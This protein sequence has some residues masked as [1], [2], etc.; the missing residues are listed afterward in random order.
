MTI[1]NLFKKKNNSVYSDKEVLYYSK[2]TY[3]VRDDYKPKQYYLNKLENINKQI[4]MYKEKYNNGEVKGLN[5]YYIILSSLYYQKINILYVLNAEYEEIKQYVKQYFKIMEEN[6]SVRQLTYTE[7]TNLLSLGYLFDIE[8]LDYNFIKQNV[9]DEKYI[10]AVLELLK[11]KI[12]ENK[13]YISKDYYYKENGFFADEFV[14][15]TDGLMKV[16]HK[17]NDQ[18]KN[19]EFINY[20]DNEKSKHYNRLLKKYEKLSEGQYIYIQAHLILNLQQLQKS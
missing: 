12:F 15:D 6:A 16:I 17:V 4:N 8:N 14:K 3:S 13:I 20:L 1:I 11:N 19:L 2:D 7:V 5:Y 18:Q 9:L 10:D